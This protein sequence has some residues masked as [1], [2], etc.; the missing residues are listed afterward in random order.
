M[1]KYCLMIGLSLCLT[2]FNAFSAYAEIDSE[3]VYEIEALNNYINNYYGI[4]F[5]EINGCLYNVDKNGDVVYGYSYDNQGNIYYTDI[6]GQGTPDK[7]MGIIKDKEGPNG[8]YFDTKGHLVNPSSSVHYY[9]YAKK[10]E[11]I[12]YIEFK[13]LNEMNNFLEYYMFQYSLTN[14]KV[15][16]YRLEKVSI[17]DNKNNVELDYVYRLSLLDNSIKRQDVVDMILSKYGM[18]EGV[19]IQEKLYSACDKIV[20]S[21]SYNME[22]EPALLTQAI[23]DNQGVC[24]QYAKIAKVL[25]EADGIDSEVMLGYFNDNKNEAHAWLKVYSYDDDIVR[26]RNVEEVSISGEELKVSTVVDSVGELNADVSDVLLP[27]D[28]LDAA[29]YRLIVMEDNILNKDVS[30]LCAGVINDIGLT[31]NV[32]ELVI[33][34]LDTLVLENGTDCEEEEVLKGEDVTADRVFLKYYYMDP[35]T[36]QAMNDYKYSNISYTEYCKRYEVSRYIEDC[37]TEE[38]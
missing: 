16:R 27:F 3:R 22:Y 13:S 8:V 11:E 9:D 23:E 26:F 18:L 25:L 7:D 17:Y 15:D 35:T 24:W 21:M 30:G 2:F 31:K 10:F 29:M 36:V 5:E 37:N 33:T 1:G 6:E 19:T 28:N 14:L 20:N 12:G 4:H 32:V 38:S 34:T